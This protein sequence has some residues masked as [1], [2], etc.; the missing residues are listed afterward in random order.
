MS[1]RRINPNLAKIHHS[2]TVREL[3]DRLGVH[4]NTI[5]HWQRHGLTP[6][7]DRRPLVF[8]GAVVRQFLKSR[9]QSRKRPCPIGTLYCFGCHE[10]RRPS[11]TS[12]EYAQTRIGAGN[13]RALCSECGTVMC[14]R[15]SE[16]AVVAVLPG[17]LVQIRQASSRLS[18]S[19]SPSSNCDLERQL[20]A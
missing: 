18:G 17:L 8:D 4:K 12:I 14:R 13:L 19:S 2:Y 20:L 6:I 16:D 5:R 11:P 3:A 10:P 1:A 7:D 9:N 15:V